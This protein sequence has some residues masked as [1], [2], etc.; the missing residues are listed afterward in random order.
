MS[1]IDPV[2]CRF[3][4]RFFLA[5]PGCGFEASREAAGRDAAPTRLDRGASNIKV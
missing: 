3:Q 1:T 5:W 2:L 4:V